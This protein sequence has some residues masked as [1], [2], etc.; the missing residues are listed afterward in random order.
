MVS[1]SISGHWESPLGHRL[2]LTSNSERSLVTIGLRR[3]LIFDTHVPKVEPEPPIEEGDTVRVRRV[4]KDEANM[5]QEGHGGIN[6][7]MIKLIGHEIKVSATLAEGDIR[8]KGYRWNPALLESVNA[9]VRPNVIKSNFLARGLS[10]C[11]AASRHEKYL[12]FSTLLHGY[13][14]DSTRV[15]AFRTAPQTS[16]I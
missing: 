2:D 3:M 13:P 10:N 9:K 11:A 16:N 14:H 4:S 1:V 8:A 12:T 7:G 15:R 6:D 5:L